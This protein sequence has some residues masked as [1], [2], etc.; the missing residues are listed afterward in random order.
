[1]AI[2]VKDLFHLEY[3]EYGEAYFGSCGKMRFRVAREPLENVHFTPVDKR[4]PAVLLATIW[5]GPYSYAAT[6]DDKKTSREFEV[7][8]E[9][10]EQITAWL[11]EEADKM[12][13]ERQ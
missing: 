8:S 1:M 2:D 11:N 10:L 3:Y 13:S 7:S 12:N 5:P 4:A 6:T 9:G